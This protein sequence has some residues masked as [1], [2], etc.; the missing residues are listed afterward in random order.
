MAE[1]KIYAKPSSLYRYRR[2]GDHAAQEV[3]AL[4][5]GY[6]FCAAYVQMNDPMEGMHRL[7]SRLIGKAT[8]TKSQQRVQD[9]LDTMGIASMAE[10]Y[11]NEPMWAHYAGNFT[12]ICIEY[13]STVSSRVWEK[14]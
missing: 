10:V 11:D 7:S 4:R 1:L 14:T 8:S 2:L 5:E 13:V 9:A 3:R 6:I 12:G